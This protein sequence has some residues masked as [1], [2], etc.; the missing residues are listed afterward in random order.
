MSHQSE[1][2]EAMFT[3]VGQALHVAYLIMSSEA[4]QSS[5]TR[6]ALMTMMSFADSLDERQTEWYFQL[7][8]QVSG[9][10][11]FRG[12]SPEDVRA[13]CALI[14]SAVESKLF[15]QEKWVLHAK[16]MQMVCSASSV[17]DRYRTAE[18]YVEQCQLALDAV[19]IPLV[20]DRQREE[21]EAA[22]YRLDRM[23]GGASVGY[24]IG[25]AAAI[26]GLSGWLLPSFPTISVFAMDAIVAKVYA[27]HAKTMISYRDM[28]KV[29]G[30]S[31]SAYSRVAPAIKDR[32]HRLELV[33][34]ERLRPYFEEQGIVEREIKT[35]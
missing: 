27:N 16:Y 28:E 31:K 26:Q 7:Q 30:G 3:S 11:N 9:S 32:L 19:C 33:A 29:F 15:N 24:S 6:K 22:M 12:L 4:R 10:I 8:G 17:Q 25:R 1:T 2:Q 13:Q 21:L 18:R 20:A 35:A 14:V 23:K 34:L 5:P